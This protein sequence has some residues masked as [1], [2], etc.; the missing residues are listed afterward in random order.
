MKILKEGYHRLFQ[1]D[2]ETALVV[3]RML[4][5]LEK[6]GM[7][8]VRRYSTQFDD[9]NPESFRMSASQIEETIAQIPSRTIQD[10]A[11]MKSTFLEV[12]PLW[13]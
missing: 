6:N 9:W 13:P 5:D 2:P 7:D 4:V 8:A 11:P 3:T 1:N 10:T 12:C